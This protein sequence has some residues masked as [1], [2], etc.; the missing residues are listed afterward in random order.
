M[1]VR[2]RGGRRSLV[3]GEGLWWVDGHPSVQTLM[4]PAEMPAARRGRRDAGDETPPP[5]PRRRVKG[6][7]TTA[8]RQ[9]RRD[10]GAETTAPRQGRR[11]K[12][13]ETPPP[14]AP[15]LP[16]C[17]RPASSL[18]RLACLTYGERCVERGPA[19]L[20]TPTRSM[21]RFHREALSTGAP[22]PQP[23]PRRR[24]RP[25]LPNSMR[26]LAFAAH[27]TYMRRSRRSLPLTLPLPVGSSPS[28][29]RRGWRCLVLASGLA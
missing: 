21:H 16:G 26:A 8:P 27:A 22:P 29:Q 18:P 1:C 24:P 9:G 19:C 15:S 5:S 7:E 3:G 2:V 10:K 13:A 4:A 20:V 25:V 12:G 23:S 11:D 17:P 6:T 28:Y 14:R